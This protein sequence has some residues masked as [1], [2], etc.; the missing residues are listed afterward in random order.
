LF[1]ARS[2]LERW[3]PEQIAG[4]LSVEYPDDPETRVSHE[5]I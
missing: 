4:W 3:S 1:V 2:E 5:I